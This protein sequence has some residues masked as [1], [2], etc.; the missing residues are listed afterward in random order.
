MRFQY[1]IVALLCMA[2]SA[3]AQKDELM[4]R[5]D[6][7]SSLQAPDA[8]P[9]EV[10]FKA[11]QSLAQVLRPGDYDAWTRV[12]PA[13]DSSSLHPRTRARLLITFID[14]ADL[15]IAEEMLGL[16]LAWGEKREDASL[17]HTFVLRLG[18]S[19]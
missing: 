10:A 7:I 9:P 17:L 14:N 2:G 19:P 16:A 18:Q 6:A 1:A 11:A 13:L 15:R 12:R 5:A 4:T 3:S 8:I